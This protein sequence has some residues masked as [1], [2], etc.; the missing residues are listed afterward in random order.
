MRLYEEKDDIQRLTVSSM[1]NFSMPFN[2]HSLGFRLALL[3][4]S[5][6]KAIVRK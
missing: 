3:R 2:A 1:T 6:I 5:G 4:H